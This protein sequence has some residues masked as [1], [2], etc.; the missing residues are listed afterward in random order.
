MN[1]IMHTTDFHMICP[2]FLYSP[3][4]VPAPSDIT[5]AAPPTAAAVPIAAP[6]LVE[7]LSA[8]VAKK[9]GDVGSFLFFIPSFTTF[10]ANCKLVHVEC[11]IGRRFM[12]VNE[13]IVTDNKLYIDI[14]NNVRL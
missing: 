2:K 12:I 9:N 1:I 4:V 7:L 14:D 3:V 11:L 8:T 10:F 13:S 5:T 6:V